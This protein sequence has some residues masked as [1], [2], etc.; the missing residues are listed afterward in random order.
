MFSGIF[1]CNWCNSRICL[2][3]FWLH[4]AVLFRC[5]AMKIEH[6]LRSLLMCGGEPHLLLRRDLKPTWDQWPMP[7]RLRR[8]QDLFICS[9]N[10]SRTHVE[11][12]DARLQKIGLCYVIEW[13]WLWFWLAWLAD[14]RGSERFDIFHAWWSWTWACDM[15]SLV[16]WWLFSLSDRFQTL[17]VLRALWD[18]CS[19]FLPRV[20]DKVYTVL[21]I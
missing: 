16:I 5:I 14:Y 17:E 10:Q 19:C 8:G 1:R 21:R 9:H 4:R 18:W 15:E 7:W 3:D 6:A 20:F 11:H 13:T 12:A 2:L